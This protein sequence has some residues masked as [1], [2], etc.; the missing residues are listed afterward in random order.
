[1]V[2]AALLVRVV[3]AAPRQDTARDKHDR[4]TIVVSGCVHG[5]T[6][7]VLRGDAVGTDAGTLILHGAKAT[8][9]ALKEHNGHEEEITGAYRQTD[10]RVG[11]VK[12][13]DVG[14]NARIM[15]GAG[16][17]RSTLVP[18]PPAL[19][20]LSVRHLNTTCRR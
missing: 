5:S 13:K 8:M 6:L 7:V 12:T 11:S 2:L 17:E 19:D 18:D 16:E 15:V 20:V 1:M 9:R 4:P 14:K 10:S 3:A